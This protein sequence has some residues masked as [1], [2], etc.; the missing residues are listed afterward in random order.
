MLEYN[1]AG[2]PGQREE[3][4]DK[5]EDEDEDEFLHQFGFGIEETC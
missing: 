5:E 1:F 3:E 4:V 2:Q